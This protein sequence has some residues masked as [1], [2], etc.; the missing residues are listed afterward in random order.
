M[1]FVNDMVV[2]AH[3]ERQLQFVYI[4][5]WLQPHLQFVDDMML[6]DHS[7][8]NFTSSTNVFWLPKFSKSLTNSGRYGAI[9]SFVL[10]ITVHI[11]MWFSWLC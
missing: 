8:V 5:K 1:L 7:I 9:R 4:L 6:V 10:S 2:V 11:L 3:L